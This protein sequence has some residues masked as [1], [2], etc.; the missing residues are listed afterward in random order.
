MNFAAVITFLYL[1]RA[2]LGISYCETTKTVDLGLHRSP[3]LG[4][5]D[6]KIGFNWFLFTGSF[7]LSLIEMLTFLRFTCFLF[8]ILS[9]Q[10]GFQKKFFKHP[11]V[12]SKTLMTNQ[13]IIVFSSVK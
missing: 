13:R 10:N 5:A 1:I 11:I 4:P 7:V 8:I 2:K 9:N 6:N 3:G 12:F